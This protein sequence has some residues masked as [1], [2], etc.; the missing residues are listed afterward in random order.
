[1]AQYPI[2]FNC[3]NCNSNHF[4][5]FG[6][7]QNIQRYKCKTCHKTFKDTTDTPLHWL[8]KKHKVARYLEAL[9]LGLSVRK[10]ANHAGI[11]KNTSFRWR[12]KFL[13]S[14]AEKPKATVE[15]TATGIAIIRLPY[16]AKGRKKAPE[17]NSSPSNSLIIV[18]E[19]TLSIHKLS[20]RR[21]SYNAS[22]Y[23]NTYFPNSKQAIVPG[24]NTHQ[25]T[26]NTPSCT[27]I[28]NRK[29]AQLFTD[30]V[31]KEVVEIQQW[32]KRFRGV[33]TKYLQQYWEWYLYL[34]KSNEIKNSFQTFQ[35]W[36]ITERC[37]KKYRVLI[38]Q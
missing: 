17:K 14:L 7:A 27:R 10:A 34:N 8:H 6:K 32:M 19:E 1:M 23:L 36:C 24:I 4:I 20:T 31:R 35:T 11:S 38:K 12:H 37:I 22:A 25:I 30:N 13:S 21:V 29:T 16:S 18:G 15:K 2:A 33:A 9:S 3:P 5:R 26:Q 28:K